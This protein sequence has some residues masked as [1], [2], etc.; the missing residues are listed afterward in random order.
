TTSNN[1]WPSQWLTCLSVNG[2]HSHQDAILRK[3]F[4]ITQYNLTNVANAQTID[5]DIPTCGM[6]YQ[7]DAIRCHLNNVTV[8][9]DNNALFC[10]PHRIGQFGVQHQLSIFTMY[11]NK[12]FWPYKTEHQ[13]QFFL[14]TVTGDMNI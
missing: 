10:N 1:I 6:A 8:F 3:H 5:K 9:R 13:L 2:K 11:G 4:A 7:I 12:E 14:C